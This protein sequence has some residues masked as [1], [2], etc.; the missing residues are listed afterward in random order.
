MLKQSLQLS[1]ILLAGLLLFT[2]CEKD[3]TESLSANEAKQSLLAVDAGLSVEL[4]NFANAEGFKALETLAAL[5]NSGSIFTTARVKEVRK[6]PNTYVRKAIANFQHMISEPSESGRTQGDEPFNYDENKGVYTWNPQIEDF[7]LTAQSNIIE[8][9]FPTEGSTTNNAVFR[10]TDYEEVSTPLGDELYSA[11]IIEATLDINNVKQASLSA[12]VTYKN[13]GTDEPNFADISYFVN[14]YTLD[15]DLDDTKA[16]ESSF[17]QYLSKGDDKLIGWDLTATYQG[18]KNLTTPTKV[19]GNVQLGSVIFNI[20]ITPPADPTEF[21]EDLND[22]ADISVSVNGKA[23]GQI[24]WVTEDGDFEA[25]PY[26]QFNDGT[27]QALS[28]I[29]DSLEQSLNDLVEIG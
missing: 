11:S 3:E 19:E 7:E 23:A 9:R 16:A 10:L 22:Y 14:P 15:I 29:F 27:K 4:E 24:I 8:L 28:E 26:V 2:A 6:N 13:N 21:T 12:E 25:T 18:A 17:S 20:V 5:T 1:T